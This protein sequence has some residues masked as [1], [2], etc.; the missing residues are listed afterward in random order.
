MR[1][2][3]PK[4]LR[5]NIARAKGYLRRDEIPRALEAIS[6]ALRQSTGTSMPR[7]ARMAAEASL[8]E[9]FNDLTRHPGMRPLLDPE[10]SGVP[11]ALSYQKGKEGLLAA[12]L[13]GLAKILLEAAERQERTAAADLERRKN[14]LLE[15]GMACFETGETTRGRAFLRRAAAEFGHEPGV[16]LGVG[17]RFASL[18]Q[19][20]DAA[21]M[22]EKALEQHPK[23]ADAYAGAVDS[24]MQALEYE[25]AEAVFKKIL[26]RF[27][28][29]ARTYGR[30]A[31][32]Y[33]AWQK[34]AKA[35]DMAVRALQLDAGQPEAREVLARLER[36]S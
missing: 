11:R 26:R 15:K 34:R 4:D 22:F 3:I 36:R 35:E 20:V 29:H 32:L 30:M 10:N 9:L 27:G 33:L 21:E 23:E 8:T 24:W 12:V 18:E 31:Q 13:D 14:D 16:H 1:N 2:L 5:E 6:L 17:Q 7:P 19:H 25:K 28:G